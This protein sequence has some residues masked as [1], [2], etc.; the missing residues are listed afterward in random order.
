MKIKLFF[1]LILLLCPFLIR[2]QISSVDSLKTMQ[3]SC[4]FRPSQLILPASLITIGALGVSTPW[5][6]SLNKNVRDGLVEWRNGHYFHADDYMQYIPVVAN[7]SLSMLGAKARH[8]YVGIFL[9]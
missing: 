6:G 3:R 5:L 1:L 4:S 7:F 8:S 9:K 2:A